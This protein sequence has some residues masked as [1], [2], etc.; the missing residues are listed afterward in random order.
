MIRVTSALW[1]SAYLRRCYGEGLPA[2][3]VRRGAEEAGAIMVVVDRLDNT[4]DL[5]G[6]APQSA[7]VEGTDDRLFQLLLKGADSPA[8]A[9]RIEKETRF[10]SDVW[11]VAIEARD[12]RSLLDTI[13]D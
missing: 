7:F 13:R 4:S 8:V 6:P 9:A 10:D 11:V 1:V 3:V 5:Y 12:G 2:V